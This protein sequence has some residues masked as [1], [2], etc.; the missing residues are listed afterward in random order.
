VFVCVCV[1]VCVWC[2]CVCVCVRARA[3]VWQHRM[4]RT[5]ELYQVAI[6]HNMPTGLQPTGWRVRVSLTCNGSETLWDT[7]RCEAGHVLAEVKDVGARTGFP[8][9]ARC[10]PGGSHVFANA[11]NERYH[12]VQT[13]RCSC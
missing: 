10:V 6:T 4:Y 11:K 5:Q 2:V 3:R 12:H 9:V 13:K 8:H 7:E 1:C